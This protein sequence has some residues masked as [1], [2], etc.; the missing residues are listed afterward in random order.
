MMTTGEI[1]EKKK[2]NQF[3]NFRIDMRQNSVEVDIAAW[4][5]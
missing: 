5:C 1:F 4:K 2:K 3:H